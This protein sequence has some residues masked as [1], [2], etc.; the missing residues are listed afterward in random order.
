MI[1]TLVDPSELP[2]ANSLPYGTPKEK[3]YRNSEINRAVYAFE[4]KIA[5]ILLALN[6]HDPKHRKSCFKKDSN[7]CR[8]VMPAEPH[9]ETSI[10]IILDAMSDRIRNMKINLKQAAPYVYMSSFKF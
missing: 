5:N 2:I 1:W 8:Y 4:V 6:C 7:E 9:D 10:K 3:E